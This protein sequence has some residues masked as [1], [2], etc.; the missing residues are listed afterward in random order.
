M[1][2]GDEHGLAE[3]VTVH[4]VH[5]CAVRVSAAFCGAPAGRRA[6]C[7]A[8][9]ARTCSDGTV[10]EARRGPCS[11]CRGGSTAR[12]RRADRLHTPSGSPVDVPGIFQ[13]SQC[14]TSIFELFAGIAGSGSCMSSTKLCVPGGTC[15]HFSSGDGRSARRLRVLVGDHAAV[16][17]RRRRHD[18]R[19]RLR[20]AAAR[21]RRV[22]V[23]R[24]GAVPARGARGSSRQSSL[25]LP[26]PS[27]S[28]SLPSVTGL[29][30]C[31]HRS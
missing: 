11:R 23:R 13:I 5:R 30:V 6:S 22:P 21:P 24:R 10:R 12:C 19:R 28:S 15:D 29:E 16:F 3:H 2:A 20:S 25:P 17:P 14:V 26:M 9:R 27:F 31:G 8:H 18:Q 4:R 1:E 7:R